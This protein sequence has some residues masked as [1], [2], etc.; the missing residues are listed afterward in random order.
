MLSDI[1]IKSIY[2]TDSDDLANDFYVPVLS[3]A[4]SYKRVSGYFSSA[5]LAL[6]SNGIEKL[7]HNQGTYK[8]LI[9]SQITESDFELIKSGYQNR[10][11]YEKIIFKHL[12]DYSELTAKQKKNFSNIAYLIEIGIMDIK[13]GF[14]NKGLFHSKFGI[15]ADN[16]SN[17]VYFSGSLNETKAAFLNNYESI[18][19][20]KN[21]S[22]E[23]DKRTIDS[24]D[25]NF[26]MLWQ[27]K[28]KN[29]VF[30][31]E[32]NEILKS[33]IIQYSKGKIIMDSALMAE[34]SLVVYYEDGVLKIEDNLENSKVD[35]KDRRIK[36][37]KRVYLKNEEL[38]NFKDNLN[39]KEIEDILKR[40]M[41][42]G[43]RTG[44]KIVVA[45]SVD[46]FIESKKFEIDDISNRG[47]MIKN[48]EES[49]HENFSLFNHIVSSEVHRNLTP[50][51]SWV[52][53]YM[54]VMRRVGN[55]S[56]PG[57]G[58]TAMVYG[59]YAYLSSKDIKEV[60][61][62]VMIG[63]KSS[64]KSWKDEFN[65][66]FKNKRKLNF[67]D[68]HSNDFH[69]RMLSK[70]INNYNLILINYESLPKYQQELSTI[71]N[72]KTML[73]F[74]EVHKIKGID[75]VYASIA[76]KI[77]QQAKYRY[78]LTGTPIPNGYQD[79]WNMLHLLYNDEYNDFFKFSEY[80]LKN[81]NP[82]LVEEFNNSLFPFYWRVTK[83]ELGVPP[84]NSDNIYVSK[85][86]PKEQEVIDLLWR[87]YRHNPFV[88]YT[89]LIQF[90]SNPSL[91]KKNIEKT[92]FI[93]SNND[94]S[95]KNEDSYDDLTFEYTKEMDDI[96]NYNI[97]ELKLINSVSTSSKFD[98]AVSKAHSLVQENKTV[99]IWC[100]FVDTMIKV[101]DRLKSKGCKVAL[102]YGDVVAS[103]REQ[104]ITDFQNN[105]YDI[106]ITNPHT[107][108]ESVSLHKVCHD[109]IYLEYSF[110]LTHMLQSR[111][112]IH[113]LGLKHSVETNYYYYI[114]EGQE[115]E[116]STIDYKIYNRL[117]EKEKIMFDSIEGTHV[118]VEF[119]NN[120]KQDILDIMTK[121]L[122]FYNEKS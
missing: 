105:E 88:L 78:V 58:K 7:V 113:R 54:S 85:A 29:F 35:E 69:P 99:L 38:W 47:L 94:N 19:V 84:V 30:V 45:N 11:R 107:L 3:E 83:K 22:N 65:F 57:S 18:T 103:E 95:V 74:D 43:K 37:L 110:N 68:I 14:T 26:D 75:G 23:S 112:R 17:K 104:I 80:D 50:I 67:L 114:L 27:N 98:N 61:Q 44:T 49:M 8:L 117:K 66:V 42:Y 6:F 55:F 48:R 116:R 101:A 21:W 91:L 33:H 70:N 24:E 118:G 20:V 34:N 28:K 102:I 2:S 40:I 62:I 36:K 72:S 111:D 64:F 59:T 122:N 89:R 120:E 92:L 121:E 63:P 100:I 31:K 76:L 4:I 9:S 71:I 46:N 10:D 81:V 90:S 79:V 56:V 115:G 60:N 39:Y 53:F 119:S 5:A 93:D 12:S 15:L 41:D 108:A 109:A 13:V 106:L 86:S 97:D 87:K 32:F 16:F 51:Q 73:I 25:S 1:N 77:A 96:P 52:S 82:L